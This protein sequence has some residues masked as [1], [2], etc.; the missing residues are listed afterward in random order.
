MGKALKVLQVQKHKVQRFF[1]C[2]CL[3]ASTTCRKNSVYS[4]KDVLCNVI[5]LDFIHIVIIS[6]YCFNAIK[7]IYVS[8]KVIK[9]LEFDAL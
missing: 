6:N 5:K 8:V 7:S 2:S 3:L 1:K 9:T 4:V